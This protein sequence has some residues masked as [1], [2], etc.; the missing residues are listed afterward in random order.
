MSNNEVSYFAGGLR[1]ERGKPVAEPLSAEEKEIVTAVM[2]ALADSDPMCAAAVTRDRVLLAEEAIRATLPDEQR[3]G[4][5]ITHHPGDVVSG[6][7]YIE[8]IDELCSPDALA[9]M[10][11]Y[12]NGRG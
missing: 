3:G 10:N 1:F 11:N 7:P 4:F 6:L 8:S 2:D 12:Q 5:E 9:K